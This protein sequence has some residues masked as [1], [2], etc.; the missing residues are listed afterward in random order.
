MDRAELAAATRSPL[1]LN[2]IRGLTLVVLVILAAWITS[3]L[4]WNVASPARIGAGATV[5]ISGGGAATATAG[6]TG[7]TGPQLDFFG[8]G[9]QPVRVSSGPYVLAGLLVNADPKASRA[10]IRNGQSD[11]IYAIGDALPNGETLAAIEKDQVILQSANGR[12]TL[13]LPKPDLSAASPLPPDALAIAPP[14]AP[15]DAG[16]AGLQAPSTINRSL[17]S[18]NAALATQLASVKTS[19]VNA[20]GGV[21]GVRIDDV[22]Q[23][24]ILRTMGLQ[25]G[26][27]IASVNGIAVHGQDSVAAIMGSL[28]GG[29]AANL[30]ILRNGTVT[31]KTINIVNK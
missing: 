25:N 16:L 22:G 30:V 4:V 15:P 23:A 2:L 1:A 18:D 29:S 12:E 8:V 27:V 7:A 24:D 31:R 14:P 10:I 11:V 28:S 13:P 20:N 17:L 19:L 6:Q 3:G 9:T 21:G 5:D 26:D